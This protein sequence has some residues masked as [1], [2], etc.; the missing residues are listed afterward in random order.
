MITTAI[1]L[2]KRSALL[3]VRVP[4][5]NS[6]TPSARIAF[7]A[8]LFLFAALLLI[9]SCS[10]LPKRDP[11]TIYE[12]ARGTSTAQADWP[13]ASWSLL[14]ARPTAG[15]MYETDRITV[16]PRPGSVQV[17]QGASWT[18]AV[19][20]LVQT[21]LIRSFEDSQKILTVARSGGVVR[22]DYQLVT[23]L[24]SFDS[25]YVDGRPQ[26]T[27]EVYAQLI[28]SVDGEVVAARSFRETET[29]AGTEVGA[30]V[31]AF[32]LSLDRVSNQ[33]VG[34]TLTNGNKRETS[35]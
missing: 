3:A 29:S 10:I 32:S 22:G 16:R 20:N 12:P 31:N 4:L 21:A 30:V 15:L 13:K 23:E 35:G 2:A 19:P 34:W 17:Y 33:I 9:T 14:V 27:V 25:I 8:S 26:A 7:K 18:D 28:R 5:T 24:R 1:A 11:S 6:A